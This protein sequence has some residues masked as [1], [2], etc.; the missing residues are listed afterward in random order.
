MSST[1]YEKTITSAEMSSE[2]NDY[3]LAQLEVQTK[4][5]SFLSAAATKSFAS[6][7]STVVVAEYG[8]STGGNSPASFNAILSAAKN[9]NVG[10]VTFIMN[11][12][13]TNDW[14]KVST[15]ISP[16]NKYK[17]HLVPRSF[18]EVVTTPESIAL[19]FSF[20]SV[21]WLSAVP[22]LNK[23]FHGMEGTAEEK[24]LYK[25]ISKND[26][27]N[28]LSAR[29]SE[30]KIGGRLVV[31]GDGE[32]PSGRYCLDESGRAF[33]NS[34]LRVAARFQSTTICDVIGHAF[35]AGYMPRSEAEVTE[36]LENEKVCGKLQLE[37]LSVEEIPC[38]YLRK[39]REDNDTEN[40]G[41]SVAM[42]W[43]VCEEA[44]LSDALSTAGFS[45]EKSNKFLA[46]CWAEHEAYAA[47]NVDECHVGHIQFFATFVRC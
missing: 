7:T 37:Q 43:K 10:D 45:E 39:Y 8:C 36:G 3:S 12:R 18:L 1:I 9:C 34:A 24:A 32:L 11:D 22:P 29:C 44:I 17:F 21:H 20:V 5:L 40:F 15:T 42:F 19:G 2:Y 14:N 26:W 4:A 25:T 27:A 47:K 23:A 33:F 28:F 38:P 16:M 31:T 30:L 35:V 46:A 6:S 41:R 13:P